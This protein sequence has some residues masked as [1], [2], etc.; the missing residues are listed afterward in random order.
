M[1]KY[2]WE[3]KTRAGEARKG[4]MEAADEQAVHERLRTE[5]ITPTKVKKAAKEIRISFG[6]GVKPKDIVIFTRQLATM[7]D[8]GLPL[9]QCLDILA[10]QTE[11]KNFARIIGNVKANVES[12]ATFSD[13]LPTHPM[14]FDELYVNLSSAG[15]IGGIPDHSLHRLSTYI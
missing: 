8:A 11:N 7:I 1:A 13:G 15:D 9:V 6:T 5:G 2:N 10:S 12:G 4:S 14:F 3:G